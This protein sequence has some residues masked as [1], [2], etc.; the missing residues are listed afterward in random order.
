MK[1][2][3]V[4]DGLNGLQPYVDLVVQGPFGNQTNVSALVDTGSNGFVSLPPE[5]ID[6]LT[7]I[8]IGTDVVELANAKSENVR[9]FGG[10]VTL[11]AQ[12]FRAPIHQIGDEPTIG[13]ALLRSY[14][15]SVD[16]VP[17]GDVQVHP[18]V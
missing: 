11:G 12:T 17:D 15:L 18:I 2:G 10:A 13:T 8:P 14:N 7:L 1:V 3:S 16:F 9:I 4:S 6:E 5:I